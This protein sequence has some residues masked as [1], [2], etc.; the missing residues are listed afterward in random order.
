M[1]TNTAR[2]IATNNGIASLAPTS[3]SG[4]GGCQQS[5][6]CA[7]SGLGKY[8][9]LNR[10]PVALP[11]EANV[12]PGDELQLSMSESDFLKT[13]M[14]V[15]L[16]PTVLTLLGAGLAASLGF[17]D[18]GAVIG[19]GSGFFGGLLLVRLIAWQPQIV[20]HQTE[21]EINQGDRA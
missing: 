1:I 11:C 18:V 15:Y 10:K 14:L 21:I 2:V 16:L 12:Q 9:S 4:C 5:S 17:D 19:A 7:V 6:A 3:R 20:I 8:I 13:G